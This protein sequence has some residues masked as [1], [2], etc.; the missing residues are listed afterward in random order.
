LYIKSSATNAE[1][2]FTVRQ[3]LAI[4]VLFIHNKATQKRTPES[5]DVNNFIFQFRHYCGARN[6]NVQV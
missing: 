6:C 2:G 5:F 4:T 3:S 1:A